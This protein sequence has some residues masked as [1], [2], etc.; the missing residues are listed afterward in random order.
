MLRVSLLGE[1]KIA[2]DAAAVKEIN[3]ARLQS[4]IAYLILHSDAPQSRSHAAF[5]FWPDTNEAQARTNLRNLLHQLRSCLPNADDFID[6]DNQTIQWR[7]DSD[8]K[9]DVLEFENA[10]RDAEK[11]S[12]KYNLQ[13]VQAGFEK[14]IA[15][16]RGELLPG[17]YDEWVFPFRDALRQKHLSALEQLSHL[18][19]EKRDY[20]SAIAYSQRLVQH[21]PLRES[22]YQSLIRLHALNNDRASALRVY[23]VCEKILKRDLDVKPSP[24][25]RE[26]YET[27]LSDEARA[28]SSISTASYFPIVGREGEWAQML[29]AWRA[30][31]KSQGP[32]VVLLCGEAGIGKTRLIEEISQWASRQGFA[33]ANA[34]CYAAEG[35][36][37]YSP[38]IS[39]LRNRPIMTLEDVWLTEIARLLPEVLS[40]KRDLPRP[41]LLT[42]EWQRVRFFEALSRA[43]LQQ[44]QPFL[45]AIDDLQW[46]DQ[47]TLD[48]LH[49]LIHY[50]RNARF[51]IVA[52]FRPEEIERGGSLEKFLRLLRTRGW[53]TEIHL[54]PLDEKATQTL[55]SHITGVE[56][57]NDTA[58]FLFRQTEGNP[59]FLVEI[60]RTG[61]SMDGELKQED[62]R[63]ISPIDPKFEKRSL[64]LKVHSILMAR[65]AQLSPQALGLAYLAATIGRE[66]SF[67]LLREASGRNEDFLVNELDELWQKGIIREHGF[68]AYDFSHDKLRAVAY[69][70]MSVGRR[71]LLHRQVAQ[72]LENIYASSTAPISHLVAAHYERGGLPERAVPYYL[73]AADNARKIFANHE[74]KI[75]LQKGLEILQSIEYFDAEMTGYAN[76]IWEG[77]GDLFNLS[78]EHENALEAFRNAQKMM[79]TSEM[80]DRARIHRKIAETYREQRH[81]LKTLDACERAE[82]ILGKQPTQDINQWWDEW[83]D[84][85]I[86]K[87]WAFYWSAKWQ[88]LE[89]LVDRISLVVKA[90]ANAFSRVRFLKASCLTNL[91]KY[92]YF[93]TEEM[94]ENSRE[95]LATSREYCSLS[96]QMEC[97]F[98]LG[99]LHLWRHEFDQAEEN[100]KLSLELTESIGNLA[101]QTL[102]LT[103]LTV[104]YRFRGRLKEVLNFALRA[105]Q[106]AETAQMPDYEAAA[107]ANLAWFNWR[108]GDL[109]EAERL[110]REAL[111]IWQN[112]PLVYP[113]QWMALWPQ[114]GFA[115][116]ENRG[117]DVNGLF[118]KLLAPT[119]QILPEELDKAIKKAIQD[120]GL[121]NQEESL[122][123]QKQVEYLAKSMGYL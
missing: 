106:V 76:N 5:L 95:N 118:Q 55:A 92:R 58:Q 105:K 87:V 7:P 117:E 48:W 23:H 13:S 20:L 27:L 50:D 28:H 45:L 47:D 114:I 65:L 113:F 30:L 32:Q 93:V 18:M 101:F 107:A 54:P 122:V 44:S 41:G 51:L 99:F 119:Q 40:H 4:F 57:A 82:R 72:A 83:I 38:I 116:A 46:C 115:M 96:N 69:D 81:Y 59:L 29:Q 85:Q 90:R 86:E 12:K 21:D 17:C 42:E 103:Y 78:A 80:I 74:A 1:F 97:L 71:H 111:N 52:G 123:I 94:L 9:L 3:A 10:I 100:L 35:K 108:K 36:L 62:L 73:Q 14:A 67:S 121:I 16:Y 15:L 110:S 53:V 102:C 75:F 77:L 68:D 24:A 2:C 60:L 22:A 26:K 61:I 91:R 70:S 31:N 79:L 43:V 66:F 34:Q 120:R 109:I 88:D 49:Y 112:S 64:P 33:A 39:W 56:I 84:V 11:A 104:L 37:A 63:S 8:F 19:E 98:E 89:E 6:S 25:T